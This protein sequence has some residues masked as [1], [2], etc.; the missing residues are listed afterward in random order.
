M[1][2]QSDQIR[3]PVAQGFYP[4]ASVDQ[5][6]SFIKGFNTPDSLPSRLSGAIVPHAGWQYS[7]RTAARTIYCLSKRSSPGLCVVFGADHSGLIK[8]SILGSGQWDTPFGRLAVAEEICNSIMAAMSH[9]LSEDFNAHSQEHSLEVIFPFVKHFF[10]NVEIIPIIVKP[11]ESSADLG[12]TIGMVLGDSDLPAIFV[13]STDLTHY[14]DVYGFTP[15][16]SGESGYAWMQSNDQ[17]MI[18]YMERCNGLDVLTE[19][20]RSQNA[21]GAGAVAAL[22]SVMESMNVHSG[23]LIEYTTSHGDGPVEHFRYGV[24]Y[25]GIVY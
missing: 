14:G 11:D 13:A 2:E 16:G 23:Q 15:A 1:I 19:A 12:R 5:I 8:H 24:G 4:G 22:C 7:G 3:Y 18:K 25:A 21:C 10:P 6:N 17:K 20:V 9:L